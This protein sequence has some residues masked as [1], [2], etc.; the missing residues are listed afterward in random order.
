MPPVAGDEYSPPSASK[1]HEKTWAT[2]PNREG[3]GTYGHEERFAER[4]RAPAVNND[5]KRRA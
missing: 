4:G 2:L 1:L 5:E 3:I